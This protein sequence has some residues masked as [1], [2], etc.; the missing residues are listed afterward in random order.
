MHKQCKLNG[1]RK[2]DDG[3]YRGIGKRGVTVAKSQLTRRF[4]NTTTHIWYE[5][6]RTQLFR[7]CI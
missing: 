7:V 3:S 2:G 4:K 5:N 6:Y 1:N